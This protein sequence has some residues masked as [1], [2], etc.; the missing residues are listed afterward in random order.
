MPPRLKTLV[1]K[2]SATRDCE[3]INSAL[4][5]ALHSISEWLQNIRW[6]WTDHSQQ[7]ADVPPLLRDSLHPSHTEEWRKSAD[8]KTKTWS[9]SADV[10]TEEGSESADRETEQGRKS[11]E[12]QGPTVAEDRD[13]MQQ[14]ELLSVVDEDAVRTKV[15]YE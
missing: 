12:R 2:T 7:Q 9:E 10:Q 5:G 1:E 13:S 15:V 4:S 8:G 11:A 14:Q 3:E 6:H